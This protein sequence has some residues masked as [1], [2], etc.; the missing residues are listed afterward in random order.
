M[1]NVRDKTIWKLKCAQHHARKLY[2]QHEMDADAPR[3]VQ[4]LRQED[5]RLQSKKVQTLREILYLVDKALR[6]NLGGM[7]AGFC[8]K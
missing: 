6:E 3:I 1:L 5:R 4:R 8:G 7:N 2:I